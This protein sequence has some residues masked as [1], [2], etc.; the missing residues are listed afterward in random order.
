MR[1]CTSAEG[2]TTPTTRHCLMRKARI[3]YKCTAV[4]S[5]VRTATETTVIIGRETRCSAN[6]GATIVA[7]PNKKLSRQNAADQGTI[8]R[9]TSEPPV[10]VLPNK[11]H[12]DQRQIQITHESMRTRMHPAKRNLLAH[13]LVYKHFAITMGNLGTPI[14]AQLLRK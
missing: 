13:N 9:S 4:S 1:P 10:W 7:L 6:F 2:K 3:S 8:I 5:T 12:L 14:T 11:K